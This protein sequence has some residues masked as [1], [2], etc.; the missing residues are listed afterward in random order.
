MKK[1]QFIFAALFI[2]SN[3]FFACGNGNKEAEEGS[4][5]EEKGIVEN[6]SEAASAVKGLGAIEKAMK[7]VEAQTNALK[8]KTP[9]TNEEL[10]NTLPETLDGL[11]RRSIRVGE[12]AAL[13]I[14]TA[15]ASY[16]S[17]DASKT[18]DVSIMDGAGESAS[19]ITGLAFY[20]F[21]IDT[22]EI[23]ED[24]T[25]KTTD[26]KGHRAKLTESKYNDEQTSTIEWIHQKRY[27]MKIE[28]KG[29][30]IDQVGNLMESLNLKNLPE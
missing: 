2:G 30:T 28:G 29:Y 10:K 11:K 21:N 7:D 18:I 13:G 16:S 5:T 25:E 15:D 22:E 19:S 6:V 12:S 20:G 27:L 23:T 3:L 17:D 9:V 1:Q 14:S 8:T 24:R 4:E 26:Y